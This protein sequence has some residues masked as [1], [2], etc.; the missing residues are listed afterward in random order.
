[1]ESRLM[2]RSSERPA[3]VIGASG[4]DM[5]G[6]LN[7][8]PDE[9]CFWNGK[10]NSADIR[11]SYG[12]VARNVA[13]NLAR[14]GQPVKLITAVGNDRT[15]KELLKYLSDCS[16]DV[17]GCLLSDRHSTSSYLA[18]LGPKGE[19]YFALEDMEV[20]G[21][22]TQT[23]I[24]SLKQQIENSSLV[25][26]DANLTPA[27]LKAVIS[28]AYKVGTPICVDAASTLLAERLLP[29][30]GKLAMV[31]ANIAEASLLQ[32]KV[33]VTDRDSSLTAARYLV[34]LGVELAIITLA[35][36]GVVYATSET[37]GHIP[38]VHT[39]VL[40]STGAGDAMTAT[41]LFG[42]LN[43]IPLDESIRLGATAASLILRYRGT[44]YPELTLEK[45][46]DELIP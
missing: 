4:L 29:Y 25:F 44:V 14:L 1:M 8:I 2:E 16:I 46:Y 39:R 15:G 12:G 43:Q 19:R 45:L 10:S 23:Y 13:E 42:L 24:R 32:D 28:Q 30:L 36:R 20:L 38:A 7:S 34:S 21:E 41:V 40:D 27:A 22:M 26:V 35:E 9:A 18:V 6:K 3:L 17:T 33:V 37:S 5:V 31:T 11:T